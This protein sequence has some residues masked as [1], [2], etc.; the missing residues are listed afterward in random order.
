MA[1]LLTEAK[2]LTTMGSSLAKVSIH[3]TN[4]SVLGA[5]NLRVHNISENLHK[6]IWKTCREMWTQIKKVKTIQESKGC[7]EEK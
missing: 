1:S 3:L 4:P 2:R 5:I 7:G 6:N